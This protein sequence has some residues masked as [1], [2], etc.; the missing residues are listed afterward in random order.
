MGIDVGSA[1]VIVAKNP[2]NCRMAYAAGTDAFID[3]DTPGPTA[4]RLERFDYQG[5]SAT[6]FP[7]GHRDPK[8]PAP[9]WIV[10]EVG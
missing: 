9:A 4:N 8:A 3:V 1:E 10:A 6:A 2:M 5:T 7:F